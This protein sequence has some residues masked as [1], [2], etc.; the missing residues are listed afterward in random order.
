VWTITSHF[1][2]EAHPCHTIGA[3]QS[4]VEA[5]C[6]CACSSTIAPKKA[7]TAIHHNGPTCARRPPPQSPPPGQHIITKQH[8]L[9]KVFLCQRRVV[10]ILAHLRTP[11]TTTIS[12]TLTKD[13]H[14]TAPTIQ[15]ILL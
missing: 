2:S 7:A 9:S 11:P 1:T 10:C 14:R 8:Q 15:R 13:H 6:R 3:Q 12:A 4:A 5:C